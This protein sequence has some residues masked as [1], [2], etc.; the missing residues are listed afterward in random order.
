MSATILLVGKPQRSTSLE[1]HW[2]VEIAPSGKQ[3]LQ[4][5]DTHTIDIIIVDAVSM[6]TSGERICQTIKAKF[7]DCPMIHLH[8]K[9]QYDTPKI[10]DVTLCAPVSARKLIGFVNRLLEDETSAT[11]QCG[12]FK[13][14]PTTRTLTAHG[15]EVQLNPKLAEL[16]ELFFK[17][18]NQVL[19]RETIMKQ[20]WDTNYMGDTRTLDV[21]IR[22]ARNVLE[23]GH[24]RPQFLKTVRGVGYCLEVQVDNS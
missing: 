8:P 13:M 22:H 3:A 17:H 10:A 20:V 18:P 19:D 21:H 7:P 24:K 15:Q 9:T 4:Y 23:N 12:P 14:N 11:I 16:L 5:A 2:K 1:R 6:R